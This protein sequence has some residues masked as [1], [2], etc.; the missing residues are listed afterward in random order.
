METLDKVVNGPQVIRAK[1]TVSLVEKVFLDIRNTFVERPY[2]SAF[3]VVGLLFAAG[4]WYRNRI[5]R[6][7]G[8]HFR[9]DD[10]HG[11]YRDRKDGLGLLGQ[12]GNGTKAD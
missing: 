12:N 1:L 4:T 3:C 5:R 2:L 11:G 9:L 10:H 7:R 6:S 8:G